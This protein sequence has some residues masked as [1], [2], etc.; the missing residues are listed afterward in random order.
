L[1]AIL[2]KSSLFGE[3]QDETI[4]DGRGHGKKE[5]GTGSWYPEWKFGKRTDMFKKDFMKL[6]TW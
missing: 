2:F 6:F 4:Q 1:L 3:V 5:E